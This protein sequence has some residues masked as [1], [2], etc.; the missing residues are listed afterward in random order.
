MQVAGYTITAA[1]MVALH[2]VYKDLIRTKNGAPTVHGKNVKRQLDS[3]ADRGFIARGGQGYFI[4]WDSP[5]AAIVQASLSF[6]I[7]AHL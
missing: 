1:Q 3:L 6:S 4:P 7:S 5:G 2:G